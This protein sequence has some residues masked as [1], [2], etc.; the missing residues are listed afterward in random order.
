MRITKLVIG[1]FAAVLFVSGGI[2]IHASKATSNGAQAMTPQSKT[3]AVLIV[4]GGDP[5]P[6]PWYV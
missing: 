4:D 6:R 2:S 1:V 5:V 3:P